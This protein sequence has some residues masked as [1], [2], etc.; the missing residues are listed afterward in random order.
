MICYL[1]MGWCIVFK[2]NL[3]PE[4]VGFNGVLLLVLGGIAY[5][6]GTVFYVLGDKI[7]YM[8]SIWHLWILLGSVLHFLC[9]ILYVI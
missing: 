5:T 4:A 7:R 6:V 2:F 1:V 9:I 3:L 8:H